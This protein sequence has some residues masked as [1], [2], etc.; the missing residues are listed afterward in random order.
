MSAER[1]QALMKDG[2]SPRG[3]GAGPAC[4]LVG[5][6]L[7][8]HTIRAFEASWQDSHEPPGGRTSVVGS[9]QRACQSASAI[10]RIAG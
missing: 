7:C 10:A 6:S 5:V 3:A 4:A 9:T 1:L 2:K 8:A